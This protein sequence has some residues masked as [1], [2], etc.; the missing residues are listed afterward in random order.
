[1]T[2]YE[3]VK[4]YRQRFKEKLVNLMGGS[5]SICKYSKCIKALEFHHTD[6]SKKDFTISQMKKLN[7]KKIFKEAQKC[8]LVCANCHREIHDGVAICPLVREI[9][10]ENLSDIWIDW[11]EINL[12]KDLENMN[13]YDVAKKYNISSQSVYKECRKRNLKNKNKRK[14]K[15]K[16]IVSKEELQKLINEK[17]IETIGKMF[18]VSGNAIK[19][20]CVKLGLELPKKGKGY[21]TKIKHL[22]VGQQ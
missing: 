10:F 17:P 5:C 19:K 20:R 22:D 9:K 21:W 12:E 3:Y 2:R 11:K 1:M 18:N 8:V 13:I 16:F 15:L 4:S 7:W 14:Q 6:S